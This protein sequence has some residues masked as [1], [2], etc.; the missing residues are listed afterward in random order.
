MCGRSWK[1]PGQGVRQ[2]ALSGPSTHS[3]VLSVCRDCA[4]LFNGFALNFFYRLEREAVSVACSKCCPGYRHRCV[5]IVGVMEYANFTCICCTP[6]RRWW[7][8]WWPPWT[9]KRQFMHAWQLSAGFLDV[10]P[11]ASLPSR[12]QRLQHWQSETNAMKRKR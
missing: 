7:K 4:F 9:P 3:K 6:F 11:G 5:H 2:P 12:W 8:R 10:W 1:L